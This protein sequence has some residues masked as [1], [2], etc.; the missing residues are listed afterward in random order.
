MKAKKHKPGRTNSMV[1]GK[2]LKTAVGE[3]GIGHEKGQVP[4]SGG[5]GCEAAG[6]RGL[7][8]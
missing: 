3:G 6:K 5:Q 7:E 4:D 8:I 1:W 2:Y